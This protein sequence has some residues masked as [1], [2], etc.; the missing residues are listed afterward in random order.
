[1]VKNVL[2]T[3]GILTSIF[4]MFF[5]SLTNGFKIDNISFKN[6]NIQGLYLKYDKKLIIDTRNI[7]IGYQGNTKT[8]DMKIKFSIEN[9]F[10]DYFIE[11]YE[12]VLFEPYLKASGKFVVDLK[13][14]SLDKIDNLN[15]NDF[16]LQFNNNL[17][18]IEA[19]SC[20][21][22]YKNNNFYFDFKN[23]SY[24]GVS[25]KGSQAAILDLNRLELKLTSKDNLKKPL[26]ELLSN[27]KIQLPLQQEYGTNEITTELMIPFDIKKEMDIKSKIILK[28]SKIYLYSIPLYA[29][30]FNIYLHNN[31][32]DAYGRLEKTNQKEK[33]L[34]YD[35]DVKFKIDF[36]TNLVNGT[37]LAN[38]FKYK[39]ISLE[40]NRGNFNLD[41]TNSF[42][43]NI[44]LEKSFISIK[45]EKF[46]LNSAQVKYTNK[47]QN[48]NSYLKLS[49]TKYPLTM[50]LNDNFKLNTLQSSGKVN[51]EFNDNNT[52][53]ST[54][55][56]TYKVDFNDST[57]IDLSIAQLKGTMLGYNSSFDNINLNYKND[58]IKGIISNIN[59]D[60][61]TTN[62]SSNLANLTID[63]NQKDTFISL[64]TNDTKLN[65]SRLLLNI[66]NTQLRYSKN[67]ITIDNN[68]TNKYI[69]TNIK[70]K[71]HLNDKKINGDIFI[72]KIK[73]ENKKNFKFFIDYKDDFIMNMPKLNLTYKKTKDENI[74]F[75]ANRLSSV[76]EYFDFITIDKKSSIL[77]TKLKN[78]ETKVDISNISI[79]LDD[80]Y[81]NLLQKDKE[82]NN[83]NE[84][85]NIYWKNSFLS[86]NNFK[87]Y[88]DKL[89][90]DR[91]KQTI[92]SK[93]IYGKTLL[94]IDKSADS[95]IIKSDYIEPTYINKIFDKEVLKDGYLNLFIT[96]SSNKYAGELNLNSTTIVQM[97]LV[98]NL[99]LFLNSTPALINPL[100]AIPTIYRLTQNKFE[101]GGYYI[102]NGIVKFKYNN[103][104]KYL[105]L[106]EIKTDGKLNDFA[107]NISMN[108]VDKIINGNLEVST[109]KDYAKVINNVPIINYLFLDD[110]GKFSIP[111]TIYG[112]IDN[113][114]YKI[115]DT[116]KENEQ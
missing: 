89:T 18:F 25:L 62:L 22:N 59:L 78:Q 15:I 42:I 11:V 76:G 90:F 107:G 112:T 70:T 36:K 52:Q 47:D 7:A 103:L 2:I 17:K 1:M 40:K 61:N 114:S 101:F 109:L 96:G 105:N 33:D 54:K 98:D 73:D 8:V 104:D 5:I 9:F 80:Y 6:I 110:K 60:D 30:N 24:E 106:Y 82:V 57:N 95:I 20:F 69:D 93:L 88:F 48:F 41:F 85:I 115:K 113:P 94:N 16:A 83:K 55:S 39:T 99:L 28:D 38:N 84:N 65:T 67:I 86:I 45:D 102:E 13:H 44:L 92:N 46:S 74:T 50:D 21:V 56:G 19:D 75:S 66:Q 68:M 97:Q 3:F 43:A 32:L 4:L 100:L 87:F 58:F 37:F 63:L 71:I 79:I 23:P 72:S 26:L 116:K 64:D 34:L 49:H 51:F 35:A 77:M 111:I 108:F 53:L 31:T 29:K 10:D 27:Y 12:Y 91:D 81:N 14:I